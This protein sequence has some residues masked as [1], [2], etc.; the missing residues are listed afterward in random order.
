FF[1]RAL[2][3]TTIRRCQTVHDRWLK[4][5]T[6]KYIPALRA[7]GFG[8]VVFTRVLS[9]DAE[10]HFTYSLQVNADDMEAYR[11]IVDELFAEY[12]ATVGALFGQRV[13]WF[14]SLMKRVEY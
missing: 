3:R 13:L 7:R 14:N 10:D 4:F 1:C 8:K 12:A 2:L 11:L 9:V 6:E 5:V